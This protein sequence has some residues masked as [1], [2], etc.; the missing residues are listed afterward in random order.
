MNQEDEAME[1]EFEA[2]QLADGNKK[3]RANVRVL[4]LLK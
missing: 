3:R 1:I 4:Q 2:I